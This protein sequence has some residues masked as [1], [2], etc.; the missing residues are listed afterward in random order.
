MIEPNGQWQAKSSDGSPRRRALRPD[1][2]E[3]GKFTTQFLERNCARKFES[4]RAT[5][6]FLHGLRQSEFS[7]G[8]LPR[9]LRCHT[10]FSTEVV[11][12]LSRRAVS[13]SWRWGRQAFLGRRQWIKTAPT[14]LAGE[15]LPVPF[16]DDFDRSVNAFEGGLIINGVGRRPQVRRPSLRVGH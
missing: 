11:T 8:R 1:Q 15:I 3:N 9:H 14:D 5:W 12:V 16:G 4:Q 10:H 13:M 7:A 2:G 6:A